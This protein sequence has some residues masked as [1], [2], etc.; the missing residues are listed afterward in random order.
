MNEADLRMHLTRHEGKRYRPY[1]CS[2]G[3]LTIGVG[4]N[5]ESS[6]L[7]E[8]IV[9][10][11][12][13]HDIEE[14]LRACRVLFPNWK[15]IPEDKQ[16]VL[17]NMSFQLGAT[18]LGGFRKMVAAVNMGLW[19]TAANEMSDSKWAKTDTPKR[20]KEL[21]DIMRKT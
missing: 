1:T 14:C 20:A 13:S 21:V 16:L 11:L 7:P 15:V 2:A 12:L 10:G 8:F 6:D 9:Q 4:H 5:L 17:A 18:R 3:K 19:D